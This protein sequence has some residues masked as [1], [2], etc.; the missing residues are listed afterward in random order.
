MV[1]VLE[2]VN[3]ELTELLDV[4]DLA[5]KKEAIRNIWFN[6]M[7]KE[8]KRWKGELELLL[9]RANISKDLSSKRFSFESVVLFS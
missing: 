2:N 6:R 1:K 9:I 3:K 7:G 8:K 5:Y 4:E